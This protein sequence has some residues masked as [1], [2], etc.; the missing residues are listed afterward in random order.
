MQALLRGVAQYM[1]TLSCM[2]AAGGLI[3]GFLYESV[4]W[5]W[6]NVGSAGFAALAFVY[7]SLLPTPPLQKAG[8]K[9]KSEGLSKALCSAEFASHAWTAF[10]MGWSFNA[11]IFVVILTLKQAFD[12]DARLI[13]FCLLLVPAG[14]LPTVFLLPH[15]TRRFGLHACITAGCLGNVV[16]CALLAGTFFSSS[17]PEE[18]ASVE[19]E[20]ERND[21]SGRSVALIVGLGLGMFF[22]LTQHNANS[23]RAKM[24]AAKYAKNATGA[25]TGVSRTYFSLGQAIGPLA[26]GLILDWSVSGP[27]LLLAAVQLSQ[28]VCMVVTRTPLWFDPVENKDASFQKAMTGTAMP[29]SLGSVRRMHRSLKMHPIIAKHAL[30]ARPCMRLARGGIF[31]CHTGAVRTHPVHLIHCVR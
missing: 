2:Y 9:Q 10:N 4:G 15:L 24:I 13:G 28:I 11:H 22:T 25:V 8:P 7:N 31:G 14:I 23:A 6:L 27:Y 21:V 16:L 20:G 1:G 19:R 29:R 18:E 17:G 5:R 12:F 30:T 3:V 26:S